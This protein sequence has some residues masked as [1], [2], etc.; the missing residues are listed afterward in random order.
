[1]KSVASGTSALDKRFAALDGLR[2]VAAISIIATHA[3]FASGRTLDNDLLA[4]VLGRLDFGVA[5]FF[6]LSGFLLYRPFVLHSVAGASRPK[7]FSFWWR[8][9]LRI[10]P[11]L[12]LT[13]VFTLGMISQHHNTPSGWWHYVLLVQV[14]DHHGLDPNL[15]QLWTL[16]VEVSFYALLPLLGMLVDRLARDARG[17]AKWHLRLI[18]ALLVVALAFNITQDRLLAGT[19]ALLWL[20]A[21]L[22]WFALGMLLALLSALPAQMSVYPRLR[23]VL[24]EWARAPGSCC[25]VAAILWLLS[26]TQLG[27][28]RTL[29]IASFWQWTIQHYL[30]GAAAFMLLLPLTLGDGGPGGSLLGREVG[31]ML[32]KLSYGVYLWHLPLL[33]LIQRNLGFVEFRGH[34]WQLFAFTAAAS[35][36]VAAVSWYLV[37]RRILRLG[38]RQRRGGGNPAIAAKQTAASAS[39]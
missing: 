35:L 14:Y 34:F 33:L 1:M 20:P 39:S 15:S 3:G 10:L 37:E 23:K 13:I 5:P 26:T 16:S 36:G 17:A 32:G 12:W 9:A 27:V 30:F 4:A 22:D 21:Y 38:T 24:R 7:V 25:A 28:P 8:R 11:A 29:T 6:L 31:R 2:G 19:Q 18:F